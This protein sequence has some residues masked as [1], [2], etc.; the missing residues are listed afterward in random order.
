DAPLTPTAKKSSKSQAA[1]EVERPASQALPPAPLSRQRRQRRL[2]WET[3]L[4][5]PAK[6]TMGDQKSI[7]LGMLLDQIREKHGLN[8]Q[9]DM[10]HVLPMLPRVMDSGSGYSG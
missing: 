5:A 4:Q 6:L 9:I 8:V 10:P 3:A 2:D 1:I 7:T